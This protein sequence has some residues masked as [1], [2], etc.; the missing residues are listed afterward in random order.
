MLNITQWWT[1][2][3]FSHNPA[4]IKNL[5]AEFMRWK[6]KATF[7]TCC[8]YLQS[9]HE[10]DDNNRVWNMYRTFQS[11]SP[12]FR[13]E[14]SLIITAWFMKRLQQN[15]NVFFEPPYEYWT[16]SSVAIKTPGC[17]CRSSTSEKVGVY[18]I[19]LAV[20]SYIIILS[21]QYKFILAILILLN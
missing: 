4:L 19:K 16:S 3:T 2:H 5:F 12:V 13:A 1:S 8:F 9:N 11:Q 18:D 21:Y 10:Y 6:W 17:K 7:R 14:S 15:P 20:M